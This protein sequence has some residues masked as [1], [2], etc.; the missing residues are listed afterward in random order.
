MAFTHNPRIVTGDSLVLCLDAADKVSYPSGG[1]T[2][3]D[4]SGNGLDGTISG[5][6]FNSGNGG[7]IVFDGTNDYVNLAAS[8]KH[9][10]GTSQYPPPPHPMGRDSGHGLLTPSYGKIQRT[11]PAGA[12]LW[13][14][15]ADTAC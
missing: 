13:R 7:S 5:A 11:R 15:A 1:T 2:W 9:Y 3:K 6:V 14:N 8:S 10:F 12:T 4:L